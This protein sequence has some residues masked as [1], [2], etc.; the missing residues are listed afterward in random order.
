M[1]DRILHPK[2]SQGQSGSRSLTVNH[3]K[4]MENDCFKEIILVGTELKQLNEKKHDLNN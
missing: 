1:K 3:R 4:L 2:M